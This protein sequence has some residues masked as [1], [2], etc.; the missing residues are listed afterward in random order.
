VDVGLED[1]ADGDAG[2]PCRLKDPL[3]VALGVDDRC[4]RPVVGE[5]GA[6]AE[7]GRLD[8]EEREQREP[9]FR[10]GP[11]LPARSLARR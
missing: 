5:V 1:A 10:P 3:D 7:L 9:S 8:R 6:I 2:T 11:V 4:D